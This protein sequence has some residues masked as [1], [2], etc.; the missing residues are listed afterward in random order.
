MTEKKLR[1]Y[2][3]TYIQTQTRT[4]IHFC[5]QPEDGF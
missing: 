5:V 4:F 2:I 1:I 3:H